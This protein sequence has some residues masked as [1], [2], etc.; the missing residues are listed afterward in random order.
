[1]PKVLC[2][3]PNASDRINGVKFTIIE[4]VGRVSDEIGA[5]AA[6]LFLSIP[7]YELVSNDAGQQEPV[8][9]PSA[10]PV[11]AKPDKAAKAV[12]RKPVAPAVPEPAAEP[13]ADQTAGDDETVF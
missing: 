7:G 6:E 2:T 3:L 11:A 13:S 4:G 9:D 12:A 1:M 10:A 5:E 8:K